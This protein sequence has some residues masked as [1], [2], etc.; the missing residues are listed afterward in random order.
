MADH[1]NRV[2]SFSGW[3]VAKVMEAW[4]IAYQ[5]KAHPDVTAE[6]LEVLGPPFQ[7]ADETPDAYGSRVSYALFALAKVV[8][9]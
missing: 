6:W 4:S 2:M 8:K 9:S 5:T 1:L 3:E 7:H